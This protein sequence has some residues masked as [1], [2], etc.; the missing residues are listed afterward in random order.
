MLKIYTLSNCDTCR[1]ATKWLRAHAIAF[2]E[3]AI[4]DTP[5]S[6]AELRAMLAAQKGELRKLFN[7][8]GRDYREQK[9][10]EKLPTL[11]EKAA[12]ALLAENGNLVKRP[13]LVGEGVALVG[14]D[15]SVWA[16]TLLR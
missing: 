16:A 7:T 3:R 5:P 9:L 10:G 14:F 2:D 6:M 13:F 4:R 1:A 11:S 15:E 12:L 8:A